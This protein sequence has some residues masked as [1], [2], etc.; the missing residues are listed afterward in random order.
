MTREDY[1]F[2]ARPSRPVI[3]ARTVQ[4]Q[5]VCLLRQRQFLGVRIPEP[6]ALTRDRVEARFF[7]PLDLGGKF[8]NLGIQPRHLLVMGLGLLF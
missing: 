6:C 1:W 5:E 4:A 7:E 2:R 8:A 3:E